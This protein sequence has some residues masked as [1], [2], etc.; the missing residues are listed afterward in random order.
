MIMTEP[1]GN[2][3]ARRSAATSAPLLSRS[4]ALPLGHFPSAWPSRL[5]SSASHF[6]VLLL[7]PC[8]GQCEVVVDG[9]NGDGALADR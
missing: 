1:G 4:G 9:A 8:C 3:D 5:L 7:R 2:T 6:R